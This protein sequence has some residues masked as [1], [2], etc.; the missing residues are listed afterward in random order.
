MKN[1][2][3]RKTRINRDR[4]EERGAF[5]K[6]RVLLRSAGRYYTDYTGDPPLTTLSILS[7]SP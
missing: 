1:D 7:P 6:L 2:F 3:E 4:N 5:N